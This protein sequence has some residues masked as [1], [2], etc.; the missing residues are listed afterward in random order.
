MLNV[1]VDQSPGNVK[2]SLGLLPVNVANAYLP[3]LAAPESL[4]ITT[5][6]PLGVVTS[7]TMSPVL[8]RGIGLG[9]V[10][11][12]YAKLGSKIFV[13]VRNKMIMCS[14]VKAPFVKT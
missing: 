5:R 13:Q 12:N 10:E 9:Y 14:V 11:N 8:K 4:S 2:S 1:P 3:I 7:G 6:E